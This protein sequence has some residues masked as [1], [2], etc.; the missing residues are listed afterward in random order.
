[1]TEPGAVCATNVRSLPGF[2]SRLDLLS[3]KCRGDVGIFRIQQWLGFRHGHGLRGFAQRHL[4]VAV[5][6]SATG[7]MRGGRRGFKT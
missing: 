2:G 5:R 1:M 7:H 3:I 6:D 4:D